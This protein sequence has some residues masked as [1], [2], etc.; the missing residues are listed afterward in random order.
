MSVEKKTILFCILKPKCKML[1]GPDRN[2][3]LSQPA[4][5]GSP[6]RQGSWAHGE[7][8]AAWHVM[9]ISSCGGDGNWS[10]LWLPDWQAL[11]NPRPFHPPCYIRVAYLA[12]EQPPLFQSGC[13]IISGNLGRVGWVAD[14][15]QHWRDLQDVE[16][17][18]V[19]HK[20]RPRVWLITRWKDP[21]QGVEK[22]VRCLYEGVKSYARS[23]VRCLC[24]GVKSYA[25]DRERCLC[26]G[27]KSY[28]QGIE[29]DVYVRVWRV[30]RASLDPIDA[31]P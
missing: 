8:R 20:F 26:E 4:G 27:V 14:P 6:G 1:E 19:L 10:N 9:Q 17:I 16:G 12:L 22:R 11:R 31:E 30:R 25:R 5:V 2:Q 7:G 29:K 15:L 18:P 21:G 13:K 3:Q 24:E 28:M 23:R